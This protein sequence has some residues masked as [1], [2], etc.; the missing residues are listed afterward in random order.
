M[1]NFGEIADFLVDLWRKK[2][3]NRKKRKSPNLWNKKGYK[4]IERSAGCI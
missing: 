4:G 1:D 3:A 2:K